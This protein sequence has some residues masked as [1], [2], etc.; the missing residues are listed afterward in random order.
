MIISQKPEENELYL[1]RSL[2]F[3]EENRHVIFSTI[4]NNPQNFLNIDG[5]VE[6]YQK[7]RELVQN[8][9]KVTI[10]D[11]STMSTTIDFDTLEDKSVTVRDRDSMKQDRI[12]IKDL[13]DYLHKKLHP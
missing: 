12:K 7:V 3:D 4:G 1:L 6:I 10:D 11:I 8:K 2:V 5:G 9:N 13:P